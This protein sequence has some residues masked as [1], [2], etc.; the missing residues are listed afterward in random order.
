MPGYKDLLFLQPKALQADLSPP[1]R[2]WLLRRYAV[3]N[4]QTRP[5]TCRQIDSIRIKLH[6]V[7]V[8]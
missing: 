7:T 8:L 5:S 2:F 6:K 1:L 3:E 4:Q